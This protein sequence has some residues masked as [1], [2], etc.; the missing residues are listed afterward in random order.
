MSGE[1]Q[2][3]IDPFCTVGTFFGSEEWCV[4]DVCYRCDKYMYGQCSMEQVALMGVVFGSALF[5]VI[6]LITVIVCTV[7]YCTRRSRNY[8]EI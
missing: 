3:T 4:G 6:L 1:G 2:A 5:I 8:N 7:M